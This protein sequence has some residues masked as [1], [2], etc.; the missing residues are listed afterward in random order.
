MDTQ[1]I[2]GLDGLDAALKEFPDKLAKK[3]L[4]RAMSQGGAILRDEMKVRAPRQAEPRSLTSG[5][6]KYGPLWRNIRMSLRFLPRDPSVLVKVGPRAKVAFYALF[7]EFGTS[8]QPAR[9]WLRPIWERLKQRTLDKIVSELR[10][11]VDKIANEV[12]R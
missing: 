9:P 8:H 3:A 5:G 6:A 1:Y 10:S 4:R 7:G 12:K 11:S 2:E